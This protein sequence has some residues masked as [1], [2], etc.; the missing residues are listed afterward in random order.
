MCRI[1]FRVGKGID[2]GNGLWT[3]EIELKDLSKFAYIWANGYYKYGLY[4]K[5]LSSEG[6][7]D[8]SDADFSYLS[9]IALY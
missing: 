1:A 3:L 7:I 4:S 9:I 6:F 2:G 8:T 5:W